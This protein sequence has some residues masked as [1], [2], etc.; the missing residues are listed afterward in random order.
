VYD[1]WVVPVDVED[2][3]L[4][5]F[6]VGGWSEEHRQVFIYDTLRIAVRTACK[7]S[8][9]VSPCLRAGSL[10]DPQID[11]IFCLNLAGGRLKLTTRG[12]AAL[13]APSSTTIRGLWRRWVSHV[14]I[15][16]LTRVEAIRASDRRTS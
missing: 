16:E 1:D 10:T 8:S 5:W 3:D 2:A 7:R 14:V 13:T 6:S 12:R 4:Q 11:N 9:S 15:D